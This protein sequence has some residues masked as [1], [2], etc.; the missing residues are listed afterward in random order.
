MKIEQKESDDTTFAVKLGKDGGKDTHHEQQ[1]QQQQATAARSTSNSNHSRISHLEHELEK[2]KSMAKCAASMIDLSS[3]DKHK[4]VL[5]GTYM[6]A[7]TQCQLL[8]KQLEELRAAPLDFHSSIPDPLRAS[9]KISS[10]IYPLRRDSD[11]GAPISHTYS[12]SPYRTS[13]SASS[14]L[15]PAP[16]PP[17]NEPVA[18]AVE[19]SDPEGID[20]IQVS[21]MDGHPL[22]DNQ[23]ESYFSNFGSLAWCLQ[24]DDNAIAVVLSFTDPS[25]YTMVLDFNHHVERRSLRL[26]PMKNGGIPVILR[27]SL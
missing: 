26:T 11:H 21:A 14:S 16:V 3:P 2:A 7:M 17:P 1:Q 6:E 9:S 13:I 25:T 20:F 19:I 12:A 4:T 23:I 22:S 18:A 27:K 10:G 24:D 15:P 5:Y 8:Q